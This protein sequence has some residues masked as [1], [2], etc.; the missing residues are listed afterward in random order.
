MSSTVVVD[1]LEGLPLLELDGEGVAVEVA[2]GLRLVE[3]GPRER[4]LQVHRPTQKVLVDEADVE[5]QV[6]QIFLHRTPAV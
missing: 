4:R 1:A 2:P 3:A 5:D 6:L